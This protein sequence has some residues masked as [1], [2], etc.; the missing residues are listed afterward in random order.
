[1]CGME[2]CGEASTVNG[3]RVWEGLMIEVGDDRVND[4]E[5]MLAR[6]TGRG[7]STYIRF[8]VS[9]RITHHYWI[10]L[11]RLPAIAITTPY[12]FHQV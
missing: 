12:T 8:S 9:P 1:V 7:I 11:S 10:A 3:V 2:S 4:V 6:D 5:R